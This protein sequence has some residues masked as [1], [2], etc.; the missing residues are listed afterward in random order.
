MGVSGR[1]RLEALMQGATAPAILADLARGKLRAKLPAL[2]Q[3]LAGRCRAHHGVLV[4]PLLAHIDDLDA[5]L[6]TLGHDIERVLTP[7][8]EMVTRRDTI[9]GSDRRTADVLIA[10][11]GGDM[12]VFPTDRHVASWAGMCP[13]HH[14]SA[15]TRQSGKTRKGNRWLRG[16]LVQA[17]L[18]A[19]RTRDGALASR[20]RRLSD[21]E[22]T[23]RRSSPSRMRSS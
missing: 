13:G 4:P 2:R 7:F 12:T 11:L 18:A 14:E 1:A 9:P 5:R 6:E 8:A 10:E 15:G 21:I 3:A 19:I 23:R 16:A 20:D 22:A 17:A